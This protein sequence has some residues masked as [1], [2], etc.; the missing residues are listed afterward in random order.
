MVPMVGPTVENQIPFVFWKLFCQVE[1]H[2]S[3]VAVMV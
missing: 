3:D 2:C 1:D